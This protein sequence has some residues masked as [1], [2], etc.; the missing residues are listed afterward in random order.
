M[1]YFFFTI[2]NSGESTNFRCFS[3]Q[4]GCHLKWL[5]RWSLISWARTKQPSNDVRF[6]I[7]DEAPRILMDYHRNACKNSTAFTSMTWQLWFI[8]NR[9]MFR[10][11]NLRTK[12]CGSVLYAHNM[13]SMIFFSTTNFHPSGNTTNCKPIFSSRSDCKNFT[14]CWISRLYLC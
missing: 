13:K 4:H 8:Q 1:R 9:M 12:K 11:C 6:F 10:E 14:A 3:R 5:K 2:L 7:L